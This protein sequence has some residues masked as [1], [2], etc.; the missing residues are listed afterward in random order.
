[1]K[2]VSIK[3]GGETLTG[4]ITDP[5]QQADS[6]VVLA[7]G[8]GG[9]KDSQPLYRTISEKMA[10][11]GYSTLRFDFTGCGESTGRFADVTLTKQVEDLGS[12]L[13]FMEAS[14]Y[15]IFGLLGSSMGG[16]VS[17]LRGDAR[18]EAMVLRNPCID[19]I[20]TLELLGLSDKTIRSRLEEEGSV[21]LKSERGD[22][23][24]GLSF[25][26]DAE[27]RDIRGRLRGITCPTLIFHGDKD[28]VVPLKQSQD[29]ISLISSRHKELRILKGAGHGLAGYEDQVLTETVEWFAR[30]LP[31]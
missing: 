22:T 30:W 18:V 24:V 15:K 14:G 21:I 27:R 23:V 19:P 26:R 11:R 1:M 17:V 20:E 28:D 10:R 5:P 29:A 9:H 6:C 31:T 16:A 12:A 3:S 8:F 25:V 4:I 2:R 7:H 13:D